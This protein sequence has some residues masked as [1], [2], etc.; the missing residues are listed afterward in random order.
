ASAATVKMLDDSVFFM[1]TVTSAILNSEGIR[2]IDFVGSLFMG[3]YHASRQY[4]HTRPHSIVAGFYR[5]FFG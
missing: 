5:V 4:A 3:G 1:Y 2:F